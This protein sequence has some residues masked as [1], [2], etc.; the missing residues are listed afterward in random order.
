MYLGTTEMKLLL[1]LTEKRE[2]YNKVKMPVKYKKRATSTNV[3]MHTIG[4]KTYNWGQ[5]T[6]HGRM[7]QRAIQV[8]QRTKMRSYTNQMK[9]MRSNKKLTPN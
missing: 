5:G 6:H 4:G 7:Q 3:Q 2:L 8:Q 1:V 9:A